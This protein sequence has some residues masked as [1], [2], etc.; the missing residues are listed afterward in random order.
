MTEIRHGRQEPALHVNSSRDM[1]TDLWSII[2]KCW[3]LALPLSFLK[4]FSTEPCVYCT[5]LADDLF[6]A[7]YTVWYFLFSFKLNGYHA[8]RQVRPRRQGSAI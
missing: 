5:H 3:E 6:L 1:R 7:G 2:G 4:F 8:I